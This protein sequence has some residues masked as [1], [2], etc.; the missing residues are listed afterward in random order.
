ME[1]KPVTPPKNNGRNKAVIMVGCLPQTRTHQRDEAPSKQKRIY[2][3]SFLSISLL[4]FC[5]SAPALA[6]APPEETT[7]KAPSQMCHVEMK[8][9]NMACPMGCAPRIEKA[10]KG[11]DGVEVAKVSFEKGSATI[12]AAKRYCEGKNTDTLVKV[13]KDAGYEGSITSQQIK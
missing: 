2:M 8:G 11:S 4:W 12:T 3:K 5:F 9:S 1:E 7:R 13:V 6:E 10:L